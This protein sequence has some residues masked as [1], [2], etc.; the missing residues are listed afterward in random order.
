MVMCTS[1]FPVEQSS[2]RASLRAAHVARGQW[3][4]RRRQRRRDGLDVR[5]PDLQRLQ[6]PSMYAPPAIFATSPARVPPRC[7]SSSSM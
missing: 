5:L 6:A 7:A 4:A 3:D 2:R 1:K